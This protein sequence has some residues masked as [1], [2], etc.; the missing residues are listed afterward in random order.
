MYYTNNI[1]LKHN[2]QITKPAGRRARE[3]KSTYKGKFRRLDRKFAP[4]W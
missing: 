1:R 2:N 3:I 4:M